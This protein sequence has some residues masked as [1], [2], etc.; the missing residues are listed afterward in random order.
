MDDI[1]ARLESRIALVPD[2]PQPGIMFRDLT[3]VFADADLFRGMVDALVAPFAGSYDVFAGIEAR[4][5]LLAGA[6][7][8][9]TDAGV[10]AV[11]K[12]GKLPRATI[13]ESY[14]LE[15]GEARLEVHA[16]DL[17]PGT[18]VLVLDDVLATGG[19]AAATCTLVE[20]AGWEVAGVAVVLELEVLGGRAALEGREV[21]S[22]LQ[23]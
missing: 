13:A 6:A 2:F 3:P 21:F 20:R 5:F 14:A 19:T 15:Y 16:D 10:L 4:G 8:M 17:P 1:R 9:R 12:A 7:S 23:A 18:R 22:L 11:R